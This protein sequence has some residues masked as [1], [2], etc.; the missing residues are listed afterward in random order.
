MILVVFM[1][2]TEGNLITIVHTSSGMCLTT[3]RFE[4]WQATQAA[5]A[6][7]QASVGPFGADD[8]LEHLRIEYP[9]DTPFSLSEV[10]SLLDR[11]NAYSWAFPDSPPRGEGLKLGSTTG[12]SLRLAIYGLQFPEAED[13]DKR[14]SWYMVDGSASTGAETWDFDFPALTCSDAPLICGWLFALSDWV[15][16]GHRDAAAPAPPWLIEPNLKFTNTS[17]TNG[18]AQITVELNLEFQPPDRRGRGQFSNPSVLNL[19]ATAEDLRR[20][21][22]DFASSIAQ[23]PVATGASRPVL[24]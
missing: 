24:D 4:N 5:F 12:D 18:R 6:D 22:I 15:E 7:Y 10:R 8:L 11:P 1:S 21:A 20:A 9:V 17:W 13:P 19:Q 3:R 23:H 16:G 2:M 14:F